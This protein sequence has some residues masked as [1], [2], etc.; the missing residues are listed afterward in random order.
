MFYLYILYSIS[1]DKYYLGYSED[2]ERR[3]LEHNN[4][5]RVTYTSKHRPWIIKKVIELSS[6]R[7][8]AMEVEKIIK[9]AK[10]RVIIEK[11]ITNANSLDDINQLVRVP[12]RRD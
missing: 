3:L 2:P 4:T 5:G 10:S 8:F 7:A 1:S 9:K 6:N 12:T 11:I